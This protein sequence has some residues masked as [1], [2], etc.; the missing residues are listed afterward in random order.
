MRVYILLAFMALS[1]NVGAQQSPNFEAYARTKDSLMH[2]AFYDRDFAV[3]KKHFNEFLAAYNRQNPKDKEEYRL[4]VEEDYYYLARAYAIK[5]DKTNAIAALEKSKYYNYKELLGETDFNAIRKEPGFVKFLNTAK[6]R[7]NKYQL[8]LQNE[9]T[10]NDN[11]Q[12]SLP[13]FTYQLAGNPNLTALRNR[14]NLDSIAGNGNDISKIINLMKWVHY[15]IPHDGSKGNPE[16]KNATSLI[17]ECRRDGKTLNCRGLAIVLN[18]VYLAAGFKS[19]FVTC[20]PKD[21]TDNDCHVINMVWSTSLNKWVW[22]DPTFMAYVMDE[23]GTLLGIEDVRERIAHG[24]PLILNPDANRNHTASQPKDWYLDYY[25]AKNLYRLDCPVSSEYSYET[26]GEGKTRAYIQLLPGKTTPETL[27]SKNAKGVD[28]YTRYYTNSPR[29][30]WAKPDGVAIAAKSDNGHT[31]A[32][33]EKVMT[34][35]K[36]CYNKASAGCIEKLLI[37]ELKGWMKEKMLANDIAELGKLRSC[38]F[39]GMELDNPY[40]DVAL[41]KMDFEKGVHCMGISLNEQNKIG[42]YRFKTYSN[43]IDWLLAKAIDKEKNSNP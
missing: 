19:R 6:N 37:P 17:R 16:I 32:D 10:Y 20:L 3:Y 24:K 5:G 31:Q 4:Q 7:K 34:A 15:L 12:N 13:P 9:A 27:V 39:L 23:E 29:T 40:Q 35:F 2:I 1:F 21:T 22:M 11:E 8:L 38:R 14:Y 30:F 18:E 33:Y 26:K 25:M 42:T 43:Y 41:F 28:V 36:D